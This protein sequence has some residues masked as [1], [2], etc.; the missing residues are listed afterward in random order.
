MVKIKENIQNTLNSRP[1]L[2][3]LVEGDKGIFHDYFTVLTKD[4]GRMV[5]SDPLDIQFLTYGFN[6]EY[7]LNKNEDRIK[8]YPY[9]LQYTN[10][11][12][13][14]ARRY[15]MT[16]EGIGLDIIEDRTHLIL[17]FALSS[18]IK[19]SQVTIEDLNAPLSDQLVVKYLHE[20]LNKFLGEEYNPTGDIITDLTLAFN[21]FWYEFPVDLTGHDSEIA[22]ISKDNDVSMESR[23]EEDV[24]EHIETYYANVLGHVMGTI[25]TDREQR[26]IKELANITLNEMDIK[27]LQENGYFWLDSH[28]R[29][30]CQEKLNQV[31]VEYVD[32][33]N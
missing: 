20:D 12:R 9:D 4:R 3:V 8:L 19:G 11:K 31:V 17:G 16:T 7:Y 14:R 24:K 22:K 15:F 33:I 23:F 10:E 13:E 6:F 27:T 28:I 1:N 5:N 26:A 32:S 21:T 30:F 25:W 29:D 18:I 2:R